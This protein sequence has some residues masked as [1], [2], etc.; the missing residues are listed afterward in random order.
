MNKPLVGALLALALLGAGAAPA[1]AGTTADTAPAATSTD[2]QVSVKAVDFAGT[3]SLSNC[4]GSVVR[5][6]ASEPDDPALVLSNGHCIESG[7]PSAGEV[8]VDQPSSR[9]FGLLNSAGSRVATLRASKIAYATMTDTDISLYQLTRTY[10]QIEGSYGIK[11]LEINAA[12]PVRGTA[13][14]VVSGYW[15][16]IY[17]CS[18]DGFAYRLKEGE[19]TWKDSVR[20]TS[21]CNTIG[22]TSGSPV[23]DN[24]TG[25]VVAVNNT[26]NEDGLR[27]TDNNPCEVDENGTVTVRQGI[28]YGQETY[29]IVPCV[30][31]DNKIDLGRAGCAL[32]K[33]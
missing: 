15:K 9:S 32:P 12:H 30:G 1:I 27:C 20:Y 4:S 14:K 33:P 31:L 8:I 17:S 16:R 22:G 25:K 2:P 26:G 3:V 13:I 10:A 28:N 18:I 24:A 11:A 29:G 6:P 5:M 23:I 7:F 19:W 21:S